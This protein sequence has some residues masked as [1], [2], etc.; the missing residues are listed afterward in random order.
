MP[1][2]TSK[3]PPL[4]DGSPLKIVR[5][6]SLAKHFDS[7]EA[8]DRW[9]ARWQETQIYRWNPERSREETFVVDTPPPTASGSLHVGHVFSYTQADV[10]VRFKR[11]SGM[12]IFYPM[13]WDDNGLPTERRVQNFYHVRCD[14]ETPYESGLELSEASAKDRKKPARLISR[15]NF[16][17]ICYELINADE[18]YFRALWRRLGLSVDWTQ[19]YQTIDDHCRTIAQR[20]FRDLWEKGLVYSSEAP[21]MWDV[22]FQTAV[23]QAEAEDKP[24]PG[25]YHHIEF[26]VDGEET[27][28]VIATTRPELL[29]ACVGVTAH[30]DDERYK[31]LFGKKALTPLFHAP[32]PIFSSEM[33]D[34]DKGSGILMVCTFGDS[35][36]VE[37]WRKEGLELRQLVGR[38]G[39]LVDV[40]F[41]QG[42]FESTQPERANQYYA[43][44]KGKN[45]NQAQKRIVELLRDPAGSAT[46]NG[47]PL[48][49]EPESIEHPVKFYEKGDRPLEYLPTRQWFARLMDQK[50]ELVKKGEEIHWHPPFMAARFRDWTENL[51]LDWCLSRQ[52]YFGVPIPV[53]YSLDGEGEPDYGRP[54]VADLH[55]MPVD[56]TVD[57]PA[58][59][60]EDQ[61]GAPNGFTADPDVFDTWFTSSLTPQISSHWGLDE[62]RHQKLFPADVRPQA[63][64]II[65]T[66]AFYTVAKAHL[67]EG[68]LPWHNVM[69]SGWILDPD[70]KKMS[71]SKGN[72]TTPLPLLEQYGADAGRYWAA[73]ARL[74]SDTA[75]DEKVWKIGKRLVTKL[76]NAGKFVLSQEAEARPISNELDRA[77]VFRLRELVEDCTRNFEGYGYA[78]SLQVTETFFWTHFTDTYLELAKSRARAFQDGAQGAEALESGSAVASLR[79]GLSVLLRLFAPV[80]PYITEE[81]WSWVFAGETGHLS[82]HTAPWPG[83]DD[84][85]DVLAPANPESFELALAAHAVINKAK[86]DAEVSMGRAVEQMAFVANA[87]THARLAP[88]VR[89]VMAAARCAGFESVE[90][91]GIEDGAFE[92]RDAIFA[93]KPQK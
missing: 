11:M 80:L 1:N 89:D 87:K 62:E 52:R 77:F 61:R 4:A 83:Q 60:T 22:D 42:V 30:P 47:A 7:S 68:A 43:E 85:V 64:D 56:P 16:I 93:P 82:I 35:T 69:V 19:E 81:V 44:L 58:G 14:P 66:W 24:Q 31:G 75:F 3:T 90:D 21:T 12:N 79:L 78:H 59:F 51:G 57:V 38:N 2:S 50:A 9:D 73:S 34:P 39:R 84:F 28:F 15:P 91:S 27:S 18:E 41:G 8:E 63:H 37:W 17:E 6:E 23:A 46:G 33:A 86:A 13:G 70:R 45:V 55:D 26:G 92:V 71:K 67:H 65:R 10:M 32:V 76:F 36:D 40:E 25:A 74:G 5:P 53:W 88:V 48:Q 72:V 20:S 49:G 29:P 54:L